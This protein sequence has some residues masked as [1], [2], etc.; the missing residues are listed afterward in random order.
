MLSASRQVEEC[1]GEGVGLSRSN[2]E[3]QGEAERY[4]RPRPDSE[5]GSYIQR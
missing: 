5:G 2:N 1:E 3:R 4:V